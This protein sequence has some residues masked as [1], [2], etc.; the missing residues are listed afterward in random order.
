MND[1]DILTTPEVVAMEAGQTVH[2]TVTRVENDVA[3]VDFGFASEG[4]ISRQEWSAAPIRSLDGLVAPGDTVRAVIRD[5]GEK[6]TLSRKAAVDGTTWQ[7]LTEHQ[8]AGEVLTVR[9]VAVV[10]GGLVADLYGVRAF[11]PASLVDVKFVADLSGYQ[12]QELSVVITEVDPEGHKVI[13]SHKRVIEN[14]SVEER[15]SAM[16]NLQVGEVVQGIV[17]RLTPFG[18]FVDIGGVDGLL[19]VSEMSWSRVD[20]PEDAVTVGQSVTVTIL[21]IDPEAG[22][23]SLSMKEAQP[24]PWSAVTAQF[25]PGE[26]V[27]GI[28]KRLTNFGAFVEVAP[29]IEGLVHVSQISDKRIA[30]PADVLAPGESVQVKILDI[31]PSEERMS[32]SIRE[33]AEKDRTPERRRQQ[34]SSS[35]EK[36]S[37]QAPPTT[38][39]DLFGDL[40][41]DRFR[42]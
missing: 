5:L 26:V 38:L 23:I 16:A 41:R 37:D 11:I 20:R 6:P 4:V 13:L 19:H 8:E 14:D 42:S 30:T 28:V 1:D 3:Y 40:L 2:G 29:G 35:A 27:Q 10:K 21:R 22:K 34:T 15:R 25:R 17:A 18:A 9:V 32:L 39:G 24:S 36:S 33:A 31:R 7:Q 12:S